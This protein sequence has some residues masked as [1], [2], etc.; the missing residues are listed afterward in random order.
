MLSKINNFFGI[1]LFDK[2]FIIMFNT[3]VIEII[4][5]IPDSDIE[6]IKLIA[7]L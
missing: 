6:N 5:K 1:V 4:F 7:I 2:T 3:F